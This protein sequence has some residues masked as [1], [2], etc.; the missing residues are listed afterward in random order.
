MVGTLR[1]AH[2][3]ELPRYASRRLRPTRNF[4]MR[5]AARGAGRTP[6]VGGKGR[7]D[8]SGFRVRQRARN[9]NRTTGTPRP[10]TCMLSRQVSWLAGQCCCPAFPKPIMVSVALLD[11]GSP[12]T[13]AGAAP[14]LAFHGRT[15]FP[16]SFGR[17]LSEEP[18]R[19]HLPATRR[20]RPTRSPTAARGGARSQ[21]RP[22][23]RKFLRLPRWRH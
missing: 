16:L 4:P 9:R 11:S 6:K 10:R 15:G 18:R 7:S 23:R 14:A 8:T 20:A 22:H 12:L 2:P 19:A 1:F 3:T 5:I 17:T 13:V 21:L